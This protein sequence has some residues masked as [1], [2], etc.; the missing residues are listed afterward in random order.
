MHTC[1]YHNKCQDQKAAEDKYF[2]FKISVILSDLI[3]IFGD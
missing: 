2:D 3:K 1:P